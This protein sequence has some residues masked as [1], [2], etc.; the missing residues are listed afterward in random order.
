METIDGKTVLVV[1]VDPGKFR[2]Y[3]LK[4]QGKESS[5]YIRING[6]SRPADA[7]R[8]QELELEGQ[9]ISYDT[10]QY[11]GE[12]LDIAE[13]L[14]LC[15]TMKRIALEGCTGKEEKS[16]VKDL[17]LEKLEDFGLLHRIGEDLHPTNGYMLLTKKPLKYAKIQCALFKGLN[18]DV[19]IDKREFSGPIYAQVEEAYQ[20]VLKHINL[21]AEI[22][23]LQRRDVYELPINAIREMIVN[24]VAHRSYLDDSCI[25]V[26]I[27]DDR[28][29]VLSPGMLYGGLDMESAKSGKSKCRNAAICEAFHYMKMIEQWGTGIPRIINQ[30]REYG[31]KEPLFEEFGD[32]VRVVMYRKKLDLDNAKL[33]SNDKELDL[34]D[35][36]LYFE[37]VKTILKNR[38]STE[39]TIKHICKLYITFGNEI[40]FDRSQ[41]AEMLGCSI[42]NASLILKTLKESGIIEHDATMERGQYAFV[43][44]EQ[45]E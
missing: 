40:A 41:I 19:F 32:G 30:C 36:K 26:S 18:R 12:G 44:F 43:A 7:R 28:V 45:L 14:E 33:D 9:R 16:Q 2:P 3:Y 11:I 37:K 24:A 6:T 10:Q 8:I 29:E 5:T 4:S 20:F 38:N 15:E 21:G 42:S 34:G 31:L 17:S 39:K 1:E 23:G 22:D 35:I 25:Q 13:A 27:F